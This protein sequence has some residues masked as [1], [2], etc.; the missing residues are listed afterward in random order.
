MRQGVDG[1]AHREE[2]PAEG[3][4]GAQGEEASWSKNEEGQPKAV[5]Y[6]PRDHQN[7]G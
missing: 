3:I 6:H 2:E 1:E 4:P 5:L 7:K